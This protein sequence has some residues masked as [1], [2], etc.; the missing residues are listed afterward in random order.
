MSGVCPQKVILI[1]S[2]ATLHFSRAEENY[3]DVVY[4]H[5]DYCVTLNK[6]LNL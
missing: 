5:Y 1:Y 4:Y 6:L 3:M 2:K